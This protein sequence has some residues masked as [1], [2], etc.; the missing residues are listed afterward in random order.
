MPNCTLVGIPKHDFDVFERHPKLF[1]DDL[2]ECCLVTLAV[3]VRSDQNV[4][5]SGGG[6]EQLRF[7]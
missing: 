1:A 7:R 6:R 3:I 5:A 4:T 2:G